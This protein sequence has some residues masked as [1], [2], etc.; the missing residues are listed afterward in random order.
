LKFE[1]GAKSDWTTLPI[2]DASHR[3]IIVIEKNEAVA[4]IPGK[5][6]IEEFKNRYPTASQLRQQNG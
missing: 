4:D 1:E 2:K 5:E 3:D 6:E